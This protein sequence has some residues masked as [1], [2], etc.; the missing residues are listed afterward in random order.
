MTRLWSIRSWAR[1][2]MPS[3]SSWRCSIARIARS[4][5]REAAPAATGPQALPAEDEPAGRLERDLHGWKPT[6]ASLSAHGRRCTDS[7]LRDIVDVPARDVW[8]DT[9]QA[10]VIVGDNASL[11]VVEL[12][13]GAIVPEHRHEHEQLGHVHR[14]IDHVHDR[15]RATRAR[16]GRDVADPLEPGRTTRSPV[17]TARS[18]STSSRRSVPT[19]MPSPAPRPGQRAGP[20]AGDANA[21]SGS[22]SASGSGDRP[23]R[24]GA[25]V[26]DAVEGRKVAD[27][28][29][30]GVHDRLLD[31]R[32]ALVQALVARQQLRPVAR[33]VV[34]EVLA[35][36]R[37]QVEDVGPDGGRAG[38]TRGPDDVGH[39]RRV[40]RQPRQDRRHAD[41]RIDA[42]R[43]SASRIARRRWRG[44]AV[45]GSVRRQM[46][47][48]ERRDRERDADLR[49]GGDAS[50]R[51]SMS[52]TISGPRVMMP[53]GVRGL[54][55]RLDRAAGQ[56][57]ATLGR[58]VRVGR[59]ADDDLLALPRTC[60]RARGGGPRRGW[61]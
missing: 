5:P 44:G 49:P 7:N 47:A 51:T 2:M 52:R 27:L 16:P 48:V 53:I 4:V 54:A 25:A 34:E 9:V 30:D 46:S 61:S 3:G 50:T 58:L 11:A 38:V 12:A 33:E 59:G 45:P 37:A 39:L 42:R 41:A 60:A 10:R 14:G 13:P 29:L 17:R 20:A 32:A 24:S 21:S 43:R 18:S 40:V 35:R 6:G 22:C 8:G 55:Q 28:A 15:R 23:D 36:A 31:V 56:P 26:R 57:E 1:A 19:G